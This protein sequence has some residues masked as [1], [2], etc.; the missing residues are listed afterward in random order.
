MGRLKIA[1]NDFALC[2]WGNRIT[3]FELI[4]NEYRRT[5]AQYTNKAPLA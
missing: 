3:N 1:Y 2:R 4:T 5:N